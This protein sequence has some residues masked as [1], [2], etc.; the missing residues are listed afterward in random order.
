MADVSAELPD[1]PRVGHGETMLVMDDEPTVRL[2]VAK[3]LEQLGYTATEAADGATELRALRSHA[4]IDLLVT[5]MGPPGA[6]NRRQVTA[7]RFMPAIF[8]AVC[9]PVDQ[10]S[11]ARF[12]TESNNFGIL[13]VLLRKHLAFATD[14]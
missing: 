6:I 7:R 13:T 14:F 11:M 5:D 3:M 1:T 12:R 9:T 4:R 8:A 2:P 10:D